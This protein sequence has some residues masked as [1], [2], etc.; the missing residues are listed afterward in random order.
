MRLLAKIPA[1]INLIP[2]NPWPGAPL[3]MLGLGAD[4]EIRRGGEPRRLCEPGAHA[5]A[6]A[7]SW[8]P[9]AS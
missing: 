3:R 1:K 5:R 2:F 4:R 9:A 7:T 6:A 8:P